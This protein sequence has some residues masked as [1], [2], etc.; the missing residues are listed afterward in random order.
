MCKVFFSI[1]NVASVLAKSS[2]L[3]REEPDAGDYPSRSSPKSLVTG[4]PRSEQEDL[5]S[6]DAVR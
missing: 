3:L 6:Y 1:A 2:Y 4:S 5:Y